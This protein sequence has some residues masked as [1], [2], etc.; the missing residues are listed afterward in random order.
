MPF[1]NSLPNKPHFTPGVPGDFLLTPGVP[2]NFLFTP[3]VP[4]GFLLTPGVPGGF[5]LPCLHPAAVPPFVAGFLCLC[6]VTP[7]YAR[8]PTVIVVLRVGCWNLEAEHRTGRHG[9]FLRLADA[10][11]C[12]V[13]IR[14]RLVFLLAAHIN[15][16]PVIPGFTFFDDD[17]LSRTREYTVTLFRQG[18]TQRN[19]RTARLLHH[20][21]KLADVKQAVPATSDF[22][23]IVVNIPAD[24]VILFTIRID[25]SDFI[26]VRDTEQFLIVRI[27]EANTFFCLL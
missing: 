7:G 12:I 4:G 6:H 3:G 13:F 9:L 11:L 15:V 18:R 23:M 16:R 1:V 22:Y 2:G 8:P 24:S 5:L 17:K 14:H 25:D 21:G 27:G 20:L 19:N 26:A 10:E